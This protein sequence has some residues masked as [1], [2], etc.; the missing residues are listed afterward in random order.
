MASCQVPSTEMF[1]QI[2]ITA[3]VHIQAS[4]IILPVSFL[5]FL[6]SP[7][8]FFFFQSI[9]MV[10]G[11]CVCARTYAHSWGPLVSSHPGA[12]EYTKAQIAWPLCLL[13]LLPDGCTQAVSATT[14]QL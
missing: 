14:F 12:S 11:V 3:Y 9:G 2:R 8:V 4:C 6:A 7:C 10:W 5:L 1:T 13:G